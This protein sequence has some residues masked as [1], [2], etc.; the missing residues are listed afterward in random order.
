[1]PIISDAYLQMDPSFLR[2]A[3]RLC[4]LQ[5][6]LELGEIN[7]NWK[8]QVSSYLVTFSSLD[9]TLTFSIQFRVLMYQIILFNI[10]I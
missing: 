7:S 1:M 9:Y 3:S 6:S 4:I 10:D 2:D 5:W 8:N